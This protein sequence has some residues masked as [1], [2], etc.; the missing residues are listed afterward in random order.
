MF[1]INCNYFLPVLGFVMIWW[2]L[3]S[4]GFLILW[5]LGYLRIDFETAVY[6]SC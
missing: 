2:G 6:N 3:K 1:R 5:F 4:L